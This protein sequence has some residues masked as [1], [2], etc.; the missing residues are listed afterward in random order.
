[1]GATFN[2]AASYQI[3][4]LG[5]A[6]NEPLIWFYIVG[7]LTTTPATFKSLINPAELPEPPWCYMLNTSSWPIAVLTTRPISAAYRP[8]LN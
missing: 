7:R 8:I 2:S 5:F 3:V 1:M 4:A 6:L